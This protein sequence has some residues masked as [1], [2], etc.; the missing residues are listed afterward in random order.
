MKYTHHT[1]RYTLADGTKVLWNRIQGYS[2]DD[3]ASQCLRPLTKAEALEVEQF[4]LD[5][6]EAWAEE[7]EREKAASLAHTDLW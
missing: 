6:D 4:E 7:C 3:Y 2:A 5:D 1:H